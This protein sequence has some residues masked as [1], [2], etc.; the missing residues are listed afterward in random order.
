[1]RPEHV[2]S[3]ALLGIAALSLIYSC[4]A[5]ARLVTYRAPLPAAGALPAGALPEMT[6]LKPLCG[7]EPQLEENLATF[8]AQEYPAY[9]VVFAT[10]DPLDPALEVARRVVQRHPDCSARL[11]TGGGQEAANPK[12]RNLLAAEPYMCGEIVVVADSDMRVEPS[13]LRSIAAAFRDDKTGA[14]TAFFGARSLPTTVSHLGALLVNDQFIPSALVATWLQPIA[15]TLGATMAVR[16]NVL[17]AI[18]GLRSLGATI[19]DDY[20]LGHL[21][22]RC[23]YRVALAST[24]PLTLVSESTLRSLLA[25]EVRWARTV[26]SVRPLGYAGSILTY[27]L[28][29]ATLDLVVNARFVGAA[30][31]FVATLAVRIALDLWAHRM[32]GIPGTA[33]PWL[34]PVREALSVGV[35]MSGL[36]GTGARWRQ[37]NVSVR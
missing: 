2:I 1:M 18:G 20:M 3:V 36:V 26:R 14:A 10:L 34:V 35:W 24:I 5:F 16:R 8:C 33:R 30:G 12:I 25:R 23:G 7:L 28:F 21:V 37:C 11:V 13:Y 9:E 27:S 31:L 22:A 32:L 17:E 6:V 19:A 15:F 29:W 4:C